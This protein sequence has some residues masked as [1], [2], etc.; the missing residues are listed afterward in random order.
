MATQV[1]NVGTIIRIT[2]TDYADSALDISSASTLEIIFEKPDGTDVTKTA[3]LTG[4]GTDGIMQYTME[5]GVLVQ[6]GTWQVQGHVVIGSQDFYG[7]IS[8]FQALDNLV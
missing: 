2:M 7:S 1:A 4:D 3:T 5:S 8:T 6:V